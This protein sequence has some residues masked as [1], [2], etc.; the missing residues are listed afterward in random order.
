MTTKPT[1]MQSDTTEPSLLDAIP[2]PAV[3]Q[4]RLGELAREERILRRLMPVALRAWDERE[5]RVSREAVTA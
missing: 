3:I 4:D 2:H 5:Q 1:K